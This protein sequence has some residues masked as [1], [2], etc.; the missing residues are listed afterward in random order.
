MTLKISGSIYTTKNDDQI[1]SGHSS[2]VAEQAN[3]P[4]IIGSVSCSEPQIIY[5]GDSRLSTR[6]DILSFTVCEAEL[7]ELDSFNNNS[8]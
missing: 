6:D 4:L 7:N 1:A 3:I 8:R 2:Q 5:N